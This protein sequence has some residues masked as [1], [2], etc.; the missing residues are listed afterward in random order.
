MTRRNTTEW[1]KLGTACVVLRRLEHEADAAHRLD[2][3]QREIAV[4]LVAQATDLHVDDVGLRVEVVVPHRF[5]Q[6]AARDDLALVAYEIFEQA[7]FAR[8]QH[9]RATVAE[10]LARA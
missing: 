2:Q 9:E 4:D 6:H 10:G 1:R 7:E 3:R 8:L 5:E